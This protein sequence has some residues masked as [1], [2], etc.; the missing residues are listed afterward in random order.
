M[1]DGRIAQRE[2]NV[3]QKHSFRWEP[4]TVEGLEKAE[5]TAMAAINK[6]SEPVESRNRDNKRGAA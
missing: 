4:E 6:K 3:N 5:R 2:Q 1:P